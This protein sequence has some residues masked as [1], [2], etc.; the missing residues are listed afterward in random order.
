VHRGVRRALG[1]GSL[2]A[3]AQLGGDGGLN[4]TRLANGLKHAV[5][6]ITAMTSEL[7]GDQW[8]PVEREATSWISARCGQRARHGSRL[9]IDHKEVGAGWSVRLCAS[10]LPPS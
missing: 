3:G 4:V 5:E 2:T 9:A 10:Q 6:A 8:P 1:H 7:T